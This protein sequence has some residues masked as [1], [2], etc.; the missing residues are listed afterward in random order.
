M[1]CKEKIGAVSLLR[2]F[3]YRSLYLRWRVVDEELLH[4]RV[5]DVH[6][7]RGTAYCCN[8]LESRRIR[9]VRE[10][11]AFDELVENVIDAA[12]KPLVRCL[13]T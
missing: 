8:Y 9:H 10:I 6:V 5:G 12:D 2:D 1:S 4:G 7:Y 3:S 11:S 13:F